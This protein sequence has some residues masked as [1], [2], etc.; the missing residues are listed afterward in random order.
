MPFVQINTRK[1]KDTATKL[2]LMKYVT[3]AV[4]DAL[5]CSPEYVTV[6]LNEIENDAWCKGGELLG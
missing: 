1:G 2:K 3:K 5:E 4:S 6:V